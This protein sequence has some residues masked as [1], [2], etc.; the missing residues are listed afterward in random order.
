MFENSKSTVFTRISVEN[1]FKSNRKKNVSSFEFSSTNNDNFFYYKS[2][3]K[4]LKEKIRI[5]EEQNSI[6]QAEVKDLRTL[7]NEY[8]SKIN[9]RKKKN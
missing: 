9:V 6:Y 1:N 5:L 4:T 8:C 3:N 7:S 2:K